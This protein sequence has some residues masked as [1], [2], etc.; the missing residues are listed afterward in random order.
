M[1]CGEGLG[2]P[3]RLSVEEARRRERRLTGRARPL[4]PQA[5]V[6]EAV[7]RHELGLEIAHLVE[8]V[9]TQQV[10]APRLGRPLIEQMER[11]PWHGLR[12]GLVGEAAPRMAARHARRKSK[13]LCELRRVE[14]LGALIC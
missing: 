14:P 8:E 10:V 6:A 13:L 1:G 7:G 11:V 5:E 3:R 9:G 2:Q 4:R 12:L